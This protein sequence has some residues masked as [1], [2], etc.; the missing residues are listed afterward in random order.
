MFDDIT[1]KGFVIFGK[2]AGIKSVVKVFKIKRPFNKIF[3]MSD[4]FDYIL[5]VFIILIMN[6]TNDF[7]QNVL[8]RR[9]STRSSEMALYS[10]VK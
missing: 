3:Q 4:L 10:Y 1:A 9:I 8:Q 6:F 2:Q 5:F 7:F